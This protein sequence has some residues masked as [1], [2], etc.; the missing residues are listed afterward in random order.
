MTLS[1]LN[2]EQV[3]LRVHALER[4]F[5]HVRLINL[6]APSNFYK[7]LFLCGQILG[8]CDHAMNRDRETERDGPLQYLWP[9]K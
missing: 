2:C 5:R 8:L 1:F 7:R 3:L 4:A 9:G 6:V